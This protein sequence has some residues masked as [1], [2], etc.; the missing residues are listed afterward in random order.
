METD[1]YGDRSLHGHSGPVRVRRFD[2]SG[3]TPVL[4]AFVE[5]AKALGFPR[6]TT[7]MA[8]RSLA[9]AMPCTE[10]LGDAVRRDGDGFILTECATA[11]GEGAWAV[12][13]V[14]AHLASS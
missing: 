12:Q 11:V 6:S 13:L 4:S 8:R 5:T 7:S 3:V 1:D 10:W 14:H 9:L 2:Y